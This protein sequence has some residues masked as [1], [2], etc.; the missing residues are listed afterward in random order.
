[1]IL[2]Y[3]SFCDQNSFRRSHTGPVSVLARTRRVG[4]RGAGIDR[5]RGGSRARGARGRRRGAR[6]TES[7]LDRV[8]TDIRSAGGVAVAHVGDVRD[9]GHL[10]TVITD[11][12]ST[13]GTI[14]VLVPC[15]GGGGMPTPT[16]TLEPDR[17]REVIETDL[18]SVF[19]TVQAALPGMLAL[20]HGRIVTVA[21]SAGRRRPR[22]TP[23]MPPPRRVS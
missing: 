2:W 21:S 6:R 12:A 14:D 20:G 23:P 8:V 22:R 9:A 4:D 16:A 1:M 3:E 5:C 7:A 18:T 11:V 19:L 13:L 15:A 10:Q 17:W